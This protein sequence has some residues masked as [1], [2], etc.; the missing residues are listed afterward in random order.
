MGYNVRYAICIVN[1]AFSNKSFISNIANT[2][3]KYNY[4]QYIEI[5]EKWALLKFL[6]FMTTLSLNTL[7]SQILLLIFNDEKNKQ[8]FKGN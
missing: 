7:M 4:Y 3:Y 1:L 6:D 8:Y 2:I 5:K